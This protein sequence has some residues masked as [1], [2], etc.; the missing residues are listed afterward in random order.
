MIKTVIMW[1]LLARGES[2]TLESHEYMSM[3]SCTSAETLIH[4]KFAKQGDLST[5]SI[6]VM[7]SC[8]EK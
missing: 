7:T 5:Y 6:I 3:D 2:I 1:V 8:T 4:Q